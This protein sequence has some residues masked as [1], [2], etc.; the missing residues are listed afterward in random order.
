[1]SDVTIARV[2]VHAWV[3]AA[4]DS[5]W[6]WVCTRCGAGCRTILGDPRMA[7]EYTPDGGDTVQAAEPACGPAQ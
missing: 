5:G 6:E 4:P 3:A 7:V 2:Q 1:M